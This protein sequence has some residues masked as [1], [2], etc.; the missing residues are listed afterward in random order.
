MTKKN[1]LILAGAP[2]LEHE[3]SIITALQVF[4]NIDKNEYNPLFVLISKDCQFELLDG[5]QNKSGYF[6]AKRVSMLFGNDGR[7]FFATH[8]TFGLQKMYID[9]AVLTTHGGMGEGGQLQGMLDMFKIPYFSCRSQA[10]AIGLNKSATKS[11]LRDKVPLVPFITYYLDKDLP[12]TLFT[13]IQ[14]QLG[15]KIILKPAK[16]GSSIG[17]KIVESELDFE[18]ALLEISQ[19]EKSVLLESFLEDIVEYNCAVKKIDSQVIYSEIEQPVKSQ[20]ILSFDD[21]YQKGGKKGDNSIE[22]NLFNSQCPADISQQ[23][24][25][26]IRDISGQIYNYLDCEGVVRIDY[27]YH[28]DQLYFSEINTIPGSLSKKLFET[29]GLSFQEQISEMIANSTTPNFDNYKWFDKSDLIKKYI[30]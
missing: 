16:L 1:I 13:Q 27:I 28:N 15:N 14:S 12:K 25:K 5:L 10:A 6:N 23:L 19:Y 2:S 9:A 22:N 21:K 11:V 7:P 20:D 30:K 4:E 17:I 3:I 29:S 24:S 8:K 18:K 26:K